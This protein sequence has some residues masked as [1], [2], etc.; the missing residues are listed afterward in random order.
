[1]SK[2][3]QDLVERADVLFYENGFHAIG[4]KRIV[5][6][7][8]VALMTLYNHFDS[9]E[10]LILEVLNQRGE[11]YFAYLE[12][13][14]SEGNAK[15]LAS[16]SRLLADSHV[17]W[18]RSE[19]SNGCMFLRAK[20]EYSFENQQIVKQ[21]VAHKESLRSFFLTHGMTEKQALQLAMLFEGATA[22]AEVHDLEDVANE[23]SDLVHMLFKE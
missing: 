17:R 3:R 6:E 5:G 20:E 13:A 4:L 10:D 19:G 2:K 14:V 8:G 23:F 16:I 1:M 9:K 11:R 15:D 12:E 7:A 22:L 18:L 21:V